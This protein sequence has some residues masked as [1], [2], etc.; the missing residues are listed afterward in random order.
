MICWYHFSDNG[1]WVDQ[2]LDG[3]SNGPFRG[4][5]GSTWEGGLR[6]VDILILSVGKFVCTRVV[7]SANYLLLAWP[8]ATK[9]GVSHCL[10]FLLDLSDAF[11][12][13]LLLLAASWTFTALLLSW[14]MSH[15]H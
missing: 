11:A 12:R 10:C 6:L 4:Q 9:E 5:K 14:L 15:F 3:G 13:Y 1:A 7:Q 2:K 8:R